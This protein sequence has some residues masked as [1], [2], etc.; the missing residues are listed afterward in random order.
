MNSI[1]ANPHNSINKNNSFKKEVNIA[2]SIKSLDNLLNIFIKKNN[3]EFYL[4][5]FVI[6]NIPYG[7]LLIDSTTRIKKINDSLINLFYLNREEILGMKTILVFN[8]NN[9]ENLISQSFNEL[10]VQTGKILFYGEED[11]ELEIEAIP[12]TIEDQSS[13]TGEEEIFLLILFKNA[14]PEIEFSKL[15]SKFV[16]NISHEMRTPL[17]SI[18]GYLETLAEDD[19]KNS[20]MV[21]KYLNKSLDEVNHLNNLIEDVLNLSHIEYKRNMMFVREYN[22]VEIIKDCISALD[23]LAKKNEIEI[24]FSYNA[25]PIN[26]K[27]D[28]ELFEKLVKNIIENTIF[29]A[30]KKINLKINLNEDKENILLEFSDN[31]IGIDEQ[32]LPYIFQRFYRGKNMFSSKNIGS[33]LGL[34]IV[35]HIVELHNGKISVISTPNIETRF[36]IIFPKKNN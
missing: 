6:E 5:D 17:T 8:N 16:A 32:D 21:K 35:K 31:G 3:K 13:E 19:L 33:G 29:H 4:F 7:I 26:F 20:K 36:S 25:N 15:R 23:L 9:L 34:A 30:G 18:K 1:D 10:K 24:N 2:E 27:T 22:L 28:I 14:T 12:I 11:I